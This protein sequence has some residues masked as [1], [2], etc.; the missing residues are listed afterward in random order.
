MQNIMNETNYCIIVRCNILDFLRNP[1]TNGIETDD[2]FARLNQQMMNW[3]N[4][5]YTWIEYYEKTNKF[6]IPSELSHYFSKIDKN[7]R[8]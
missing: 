7:M 6:P 5:F 8:R 2:N 3:L 1:Q 4:A